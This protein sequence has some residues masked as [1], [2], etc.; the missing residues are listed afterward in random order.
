VEKKERESKI[1]RK[2]ETG[3]PRRGAGTQAEELEL[4]KHNQKKERKKLAQI[5]E[6]RQGPGEGR[7]RFGKWRKAGLYNQ[8]G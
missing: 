8:A 2:R 1:G 3:K 5:V 6:D 7:T 4:Q